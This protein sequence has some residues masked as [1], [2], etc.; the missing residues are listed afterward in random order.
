V[1]VEKSIVR[2][3]AKRLCTARV[4]RADTGFGRSEARLSTWRSI[5]SP[6]G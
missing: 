3:H 4:G 5:G 6:L 2:S 1:E